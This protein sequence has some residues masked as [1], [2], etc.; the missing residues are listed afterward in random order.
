MEELL[1]CST[2]VGERNMGCLKYKDFR[3]VFFPEA[4]KAKDITMRVGGCE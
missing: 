2:R 4:D 1:S 3:G